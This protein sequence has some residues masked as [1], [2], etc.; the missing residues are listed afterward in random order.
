MFYPH[1]DR[2]IRICDNEG[3]MIVKHLNSNSLIDCNNW[4]FEALCSFNLQS[5]F[6][7]LWSETLTWIWWY[8]L[9]FI[10]CVS[11]NSFKYGIYIQFNVKHPKPLI[12][13][14]WYTDWDNVANEPQPKWL[15]LLPQSLSLPFCVSMYM[16]LF[17]LYM[18]S[19]K[20]MQYICVY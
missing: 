15:F 16:L 11:G 10:G 13:F 3:W 4:W 2:K 9:Y 8:C 6:W 20:I 14:D 1:K 19:K 5:Y 7:T 18:C 12:A 17:S